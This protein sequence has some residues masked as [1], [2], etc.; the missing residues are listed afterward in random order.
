MADGDHGWNRKWTSQGMVTDE[1]DQRHWY[2][3]A[4]L[5]LPAKRKEN[6]SPPPTPGSNTG[7]TMVGLVLTSEEQGRFPKPQAGLGEG[8]RTSWQ[9]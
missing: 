5:D 4:G 7:I 9:G 6:K 3:S 1:E 8:E 2:S